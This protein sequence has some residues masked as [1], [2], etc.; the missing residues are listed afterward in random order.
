MI[1]S[2]YK[3]AMN[4]YLKKPL[5]NNGAQGVPQYMFTIIK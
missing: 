1:I 3:L 5:L 4:D 2:G